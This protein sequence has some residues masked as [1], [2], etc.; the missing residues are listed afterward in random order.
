MSRRIADLEP[1]T[2]DLCNQ[3]LAACGRAGHLVTVTQTLRTMEEQARIYAQGRTM[4]GAIIT[5]APP[6]TSAHNFGM[7]FDICIAGA[8]PYPAGFDWEA[9]GVIG[10]ALGLGW[11]GRFSHPD[12][13]H[14][15]R[16]DWRSAGKT[17][18]G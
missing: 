14:F 10:E 7:A 9:L 18:G 17:A 11:G 1:H 6:G 16:L 15:E 5:Y 12:L 13:D 3:F 8:E 2:Q 4:P